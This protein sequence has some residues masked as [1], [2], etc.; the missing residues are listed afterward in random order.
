M[1]KIYIIGIGPGSKDYLTQIAI[2][3]TE[4]SDVVIGSKRALDLF[5][6]LHDKIEFNVK[7]LHENLEE[8]VN[9]AVNGKT[10]SLLST[11]DPGFSGLLKPILKIAK[12]KNFSVNNIEV[13]PAVSSLQLASAKVKIPWDDANIMT[14]HGRENK[15]EILETIDNGKVTITLP[16]K[17]VKDMAE[18]LI[19]SGVNPERKVIICERLSYENERILESTLNNVLDSDFTYMCIMVIF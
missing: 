18:F 12:E 6:N 3:T 2:K 14:F 19:K 17:S 9:L 16:S 5:D 8:S 4:K 1:S 10:V 15:G 13:I 7:N 11:G